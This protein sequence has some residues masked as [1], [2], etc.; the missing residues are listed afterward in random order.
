MIGSLFAG[1]DEAP[2][3]LVLF[4]GRS[5][6]VYRGMGSLGAMAPAAATA[7]SSD[8]KVEPRSSCPEG[9]EGRV[10]YRGPLGSRRSTSSSAACAPAWATPARRTIENAAARRALRAH[11]RRPVSA[12]ATCTT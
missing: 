1:T 9:I 2:G 8:G 12:R 10:P 5:F 3:E 6:K 11:H 7:I 4:Q